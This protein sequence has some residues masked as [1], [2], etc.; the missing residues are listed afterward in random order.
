MNT[1]ECKK[2]EVESALAQA[3]AFVSG[4]DG[5]PRHMDSYMTVMDFEITEATLKS[6]KD[7]YTKEEWEAMSEDWMFHKYHSPMCGLLSL[8]VNRVILNK[9][10]AEKKEG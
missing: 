3:N 4:I 10:L 5:T 1:R 2:E 6:M 9:P 7:N 8:V